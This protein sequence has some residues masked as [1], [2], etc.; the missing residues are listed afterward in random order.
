MQD[1]ADRLSDRVEE[2]ALGQCAGLYNDALRRCMRRFALVFK[3][4][5]ELETKKPPT[6]YETPE[7]QQKWRED[8]RRTILR[9][10]GMSKAVSREIATAGAQCAD[11]IRAAME[12]IDRIN[13]VGDDI[14]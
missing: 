11:V 12:D 8:Q 7:Q 14:G 9:R 10:S 1:R 6:A 3:Q 5:E 4:L 2:K 13:R